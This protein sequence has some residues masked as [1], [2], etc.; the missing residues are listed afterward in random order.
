MNLAALSALTWEQRIFFG[1]LLLIF[2]SQASA[3]FG[4]LRHKT[5]TDRGSA[6]AVVGAWYLVLGLSLA[7]AWL[8]PRLTPDP[9]AVGFVGLGIFV[10]GSTLRWVAVST[11]DKHFS[12][13]VELQEEHQL[14]TH[15]IY[16]WVRH[17]AYLGSLCWTLSVP[18]FLGSGAGL[19]AFV[20]AYIPA[21]RY[22]IR[23][24][25]A[26]LGDYFGTA[27]ETYRE[28]VPALLPRPPV[29]SAD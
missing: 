20:A 13:L 26:V 2:V 28:R 24:E 5:T 18:L 17:P 8:F 21:L 3:L 23:V 7:E 25:E 12:P 29:P 1:L 16:A 19:V 10:A 4:L 6:W 27:W 14:V 22:R 9:R 11:L 15:G